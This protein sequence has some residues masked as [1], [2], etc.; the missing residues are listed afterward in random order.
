METKKNTN[1]III[2]GIFFLAN[3]LL[4]GCDSPEDSVQQRGASRQFDEP[5]VENVMNLKKVGVMTELQET[6]P[7]EYKIQKEYPSN[8]TGVVIKRRDGSQEIVPEETVQSLIDNPQTGRMRGVSTALSAGLLGYMMGKTTNLNSRY[9]AND[10]LFNQSLTNKNLIDE[11]KRED[12]HGPS[13]RSYWFGSGRYYSGT[14]QRPVG[15]G[16]ATAGRT[17]FFSRLSSSFRGFMG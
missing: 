13:F 8:V 12:E 2:G 5:E 4:I 3:T 7:N 11:R 6:A 17:G 9:Y 16:K 10:A 1:R 15:V 14:A